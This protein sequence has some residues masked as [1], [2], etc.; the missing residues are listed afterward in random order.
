MTKQSTLLIGTYTKKEGHV[1]GKAEGI[2]LAQMDHKTGQITATDTITDIINP[3]YAIINANNDVIYAV[4]ELADTFPAG[5][6]YAY[7]INNDE[8]NFEK[9]S[10]LST[11]GNAPCHLYLDE[12]RKRL[13]VVN[14]MGGIINYGINEDGSVKDNPQVLKYEG[15]SLVTPRQEAPHPH[16][17]QAVENLVLVTD[18]GTDQIITFKSENSGGLTELSRT[19]TSAGGG[20]RHFDVNRQNGVLYVTNE[21]NLTIQIFKLN[22]EGGEMELLQTI[23]LHNGLSDATG[24]SGAAIKVHPSGKYLYASMRASNDSPDNSIQHCNIQNDGSLIHSGSTHSHGSVPRDFEIS[25]DGKFL[26]VAHQNSDDLV[27]FQIDQKT[28]NLKHQ[29]IVSS[30]KTPVSLKFF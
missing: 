5:K 24:H 19:S 21:L 20:P 9:I 26:I 18:L 7:S 2:Y 25:R 22:S 14:Y 4:S 12:S 13:Y 23:P 28:G 3:S 17:V 27:T 11:Y 6:V 10:E 15:G 29:K 8:N 30:I 1:D 16:M